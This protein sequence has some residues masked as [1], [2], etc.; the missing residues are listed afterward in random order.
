MVTDRRFAHFKKDVAL[1]RM[2]QIPEGGS[3]IS[4]FIFIT[5]TERPY[6][7]VMGR[8]NKEAPWDSIGALDQERVE[9]HSAGCCPPQPS[10]WASLRMTQPREY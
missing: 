7:V 5:K 1:P 6:E 8:I 2:K 3:C 9:R 10:Y 4:V